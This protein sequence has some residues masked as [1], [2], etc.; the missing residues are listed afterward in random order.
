MADEIYIPVK[1]VGLE[2]VQQQINQIVANLSSKTAQVGP[3]TAGVGTRVAGAARASTIIAPPLAREGAR[4]SSMARAAHREAMASI[5]PEAQFES[6]A[7]KTAANWRKIDERVLTARQKHL[8]GLAKA[9]KSELMSSIVPMESFEQ[10]A[11]EISQRYRKMEEAERQKRVAQLS[12]HAAKAHAE[13]LASI[14]PA[15]AFEEAA[16]KT[17]AYYKHLNELDSNYRNAS[18]RE[19]RMMKKEREY[20]QLD[21]V[22]SELQDDKRIQAQRSKMLRH[23]EA[24][25][26]LARMQKNRERM[27]SQA[28]MGLASTAIGLFGTSGFAALNIAFASMSGMKYAGI[29]AVATSLGEVTRGLLNLRESAL[30]TADS[31]KV[32]TRAYQLQQARAAAVEA[33]MG[34]AAQPTEQRTLASKEALM[35]RP[36]GLTGMSVFSGIWGEVNPWQVA[37]RAYAHPLSTMWNLRNATAQGV[38]QGIGLRGLGQGISDAAGYKDRL[39]EARQHMLEERE[40]FRAHFES[41]DEMWRRIQSAAASRYTDKDRELREQSNALKA[42]ADNTGQSASYLKEMSGGGVTGVVGGLARAIYQ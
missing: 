2:R 1:L 7:A 16:E 31:L 41:A 27:Y 29:G 14:V 5:F 21:V 9:A 15:T 26:R 19:R 12:K 22:Q 39:K 4:L 33:A 23:A 32:T 36:G 38:I 25:E 37:A 20:R 18:V 17:A 35:S 30:K 10:K 28:T 34:V 8:R 13:T 40:P 6:E 24:Q 42:I 11:I 3:S